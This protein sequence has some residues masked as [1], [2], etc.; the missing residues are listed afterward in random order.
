MNTEQKV[1]ALI[2]PLMI[3]PW[4]NKRQYLLACE[5]KKPI[6]TNAEQRTADHA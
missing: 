3:I 2:K 4:P 6:G 5:A 1:V